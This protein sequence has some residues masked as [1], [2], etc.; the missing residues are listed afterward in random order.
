MVSGTG[1]RVE[2]FGWTH[3]GRAEPALR[4][5]TFHVEPGEKFCC[6]ATPVLAS[7]RSWRLLPECSVA[8]KKASR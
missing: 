3:A 5:V 7:P 6:A 1:I 4:D 2:G 8:M